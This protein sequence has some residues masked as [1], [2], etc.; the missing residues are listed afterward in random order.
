M[1]ENLRL[2][3]LN[4]NEKRVFSSQVSIDERNLSC[5]FLK[6]ME[7]SSH[8]YTTNLDK[9]TYDQDDDDEAANAI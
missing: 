8:I 2:A 4:L 9:S 1:G 5:S 6:L 3:I 7:R